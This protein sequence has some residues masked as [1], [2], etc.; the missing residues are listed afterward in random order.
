MKK[1]Y[2][3]PE[4]E[5]VKIASHVSLLAGS[6]LNE[7]LQDIEGETNSGWADVREYDMDM[8]EFD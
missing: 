5:V 2:M 3:T 1:R 7:F 4:A 6:D 8:S